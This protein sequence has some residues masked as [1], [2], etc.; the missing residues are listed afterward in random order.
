MQHPP[1]PPL[2]LFT[3]ARQDKYEAELKKEIK[4]LQ[5]FRFAP[6][7]TPAR[8]TIAPAQRARLRDQIK[9]WLT[10][11]TVKEKQPLLEARKAIESDMVSARSL[12]LR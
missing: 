9:T 10:S 1:P 11:D 8:N 12:A 6:S 2:L 7:S 5:R 3:Q 4:K